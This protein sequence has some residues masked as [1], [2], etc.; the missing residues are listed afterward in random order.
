MTTNPTP[1]TSTAPAAATVVRFSSG[2]AFVDVTIT[3]DNA[4]IRDFRS[5]LPLSLRFEEFNG[6]EKI[7]YLPRPLDTTD[8][9]GSDPEDGDLIYYTPWGNLGFYY[10][11]AGIEHSDQ[12]IHLG[13]FT[14]TVDQLT[15]LEGGDVTLAILEQ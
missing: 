12:V 9:P 1:D 7:S 4:T 3:D 6:R 14:A 2:D 5:M 11:A 15:Q 8:T 13:T 10:D